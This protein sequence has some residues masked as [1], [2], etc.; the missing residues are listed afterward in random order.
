MSE[1]EYDPVLG[2]TYGYP[3]LEFMKKGWIRFCVGWSLLGLDEDEPALYFDYYF[4][5]DEWVLILDQFY[6]SAHIFKDEKIAFSFPWYP[7]YEE[8]LSPEVII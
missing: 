4:S 5:E 7:Y 6:F 2:D 1:Q 8:Y 3:K